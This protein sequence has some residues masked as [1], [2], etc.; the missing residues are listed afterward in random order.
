LICVGDKHLLLPSSVNIAGRPLNF[1]DDLDIGGDGSIYFTDTSRYRLRDMFLDL[2]DGRGT[3]RL[4]SVHIRDVTD[5]K[6]ESDGI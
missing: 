5:S 6:S 1:L 2:L 3:G 4:I